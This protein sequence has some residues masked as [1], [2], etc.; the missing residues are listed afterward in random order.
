MKPIIV[1]VDFAF[2]DRFDRPRMIVCGAASYCLAVNVE[3]QL[4]V[5]PLDSPHGPRRDKDSIP[6]PPVFRID[7]QKKNTP[8]FILDQEILNVSNFA[9]TGVDMISVNFL[10]TCPPAV[11]EAYY[12]EELC[13]ASA[14]SG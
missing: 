8:V 14:P 6:R 12:R 1:F 5:G 7:Y 10:D 2:V 9:V 11:P 4:L 13:D 3:V